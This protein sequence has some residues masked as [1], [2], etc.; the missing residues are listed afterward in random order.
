MQM[1]GRTEWERNGLQSIYLR[2]SGGQGCELYQTF[3]VHFQ[4]HSV[5]DQ[6]VSLDGEAADKKT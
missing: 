6:P 3:I 4:P 2:R 1:W 5:S